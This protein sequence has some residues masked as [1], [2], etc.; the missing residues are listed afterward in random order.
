[1]STKDIIR[2]HQYSDYIYQDSSYW[3]QFYCQEA[4]NLPYD[5]ITHLDQN[6]HKLK[7]FWVRTLCA[8]CDQELFTNEQAELIKTLHRMG[9]IRSVE[10]F[11]NLIGYE[12]HDE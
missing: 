6:I 10:E 8:G 12:T 11:L 7:N 1:M 9:G 5:M 4:M 3:I 2:K